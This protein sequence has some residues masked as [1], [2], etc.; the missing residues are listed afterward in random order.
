MADGDPLD[1]LIVGAGPTGLTAALDLANFGL[2]VRLIDKAPAPSVTSKALVVQ[3]RTLESLAFA[4]PGLPEAMTAKGS[5]LRSMTPVVDGKRILRIR[6]D[7][8]A[9]PYRHPLILPQSDTERFLAERLERLDGPRVERST[10]LLDFAHDESGVEATLQRPDGSTESVRAQWLLGCDGAHSAVRHGL[11][12]AFEGSAYA[13][14]FM[15]ADVRVDGP[16]PEGEGFAF[17]SANGLIAAI[18]MPGVRRYRLIATVPVGETPSANEPA[19]DDFQRLCDR[20][21]PEKIRLADPTWLAYFH[22]HRRLASRFRVDRAFLLGD[23]A[24]IHSPAGGQG[25]NTGIQ[26]ALNLSWKLAAVIRGRSPAHILDSYEAERRPVAVEVLQA[27]DTLFRAVLAREGWAWWARRQLLPLLVN[28]PGMLHRFQMFITELALHYPHSPIL[29]SGR[30]PWDASPGPAPGHRAP[31]VALV[32]AEDGCGTS[33]FALLSDRRHQLLLLPGDDPGAEVPRALERVALAVNEA[34]GDAVSIRRIGD[35]RIDSAGLARGRYGD[36]SSS[37]TLVRPDGYVAARGRPYDP[38]TVL[39]A[40]A[41]ALGRD[42]TKTIE[43]SAGAG[44][45]VAD[46]TP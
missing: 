23:A 29:P 26:D 15:L 31:D 8:V 18:A 12:V 2:D 32:S 5:P 42:S 21:I 41:H 35:D 22:L 34:F 17:A 24:H 3:P 30:G 28:R 33:L 25:M 14:T 44:P 43:P 6:F 4:A 27:T 38:A 19:L 10:A 7:G 45:V 46:A 36:E 40:V 39:D 1:V 11:D 37:Y 16:L 9:S 20:L 13:E